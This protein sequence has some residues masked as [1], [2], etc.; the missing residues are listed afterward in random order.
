LWNVS[1]EY[2]ASSN[3]SKARKDADDAELAR[4]LWQ[5]SEKIAA[6]VGATR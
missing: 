4:A 6:E 5:A 1:G 3:V 2:L